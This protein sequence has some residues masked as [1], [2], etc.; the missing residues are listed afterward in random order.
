MFNKSVYI[1]NETQADGSIVKKQVSGAEFYKA[2][3]ES[4]ALPLD[5]RRYFITD[6]FM[7][8]GYEDT[9]VIEVTREKYLEWRR[10][11]RGSDKDDKDDK[12]RKD[13]KRGKP[14][15]ARADSR[16][17]KPQTPRYKF[18]SIEAMT[19]KGVPS[20]FAGALL[21]ADDEDNRI[22]R[23]ALEELVRKVAAWKPWASDMLKLRMMG[24]NNADCAAMIAKRYRVTERMG[25]HYREQL[26]KFLENFK[27]DMM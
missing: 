10:E 22:R 5:Q 4:N 27:R 21:S 8:D 6:R 16:R 26:D 24:F 11:R 7:Y 3:Q 18:V 25:R 20:D 17:D 9:L 19:E 13:S 12:N 14:K 1:M 15:K 23:V 2:V